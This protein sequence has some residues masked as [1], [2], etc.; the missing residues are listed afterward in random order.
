MYAGG[1]EP[2]AMGGAT[3][4]EDG[5][6][7]Q[8]VIPT[9]GKTEALNCQGDQEPSIWFAD[10]D[11]DGFGDIGDYVCSCAEVSGRVENSDDCDDEDAVVHPG[12]E[13]IC[14]DGVD[15]D[16]DFLID[17]GTENLVTWYLDRDGDGFGDP[18]QSLESCAQVGAS[19]LVAGD[20]NDFDAAIH[21]DA[22]EVC[23]PFDVDEDCSGAADDA[24]EGLADEDKTAWYLDGDEDGY[25]SGDPIMR[26]NQP[27]GRVTDDSDCN[28]ENGDIHPGAEEICDEAQTDENCNGSA[29]DLDSTVAAGSL[30]AWY[31]DSDVDSYGDANQMVASCLAPAGYVEN[32][33]DCDDTDKSLS[34]FVEYYYDSDGDGYGADS[35]QPGGGYLQSCSDHLAIGSTESGTYS[36]QPFEEMP[37]RNLTVECDMV[38]DSG[39]WTLVFSHDFAAAGELFTD[40]DEAA[41]KNPED[42]SA[43]LYSILGYLSS[44]EREE[45]NFE[46]RLE[47]PGSDYA[48]HTW[49]QGT[50]PVGYSFVQDYEETSAPQAD[51]GGWGGLA[52][53]STSLSFLDGSPN[54]T[55]RYFSVGA[56]ESISQE[57]IEGL[58]GPGL[59]PVDSVRL[60][61]RKGRARVVQACAMPDGY[62]TD[63]SDCY[64]EDAF[65]YPGAPDICDGRINDCTA[66]A[67]NESGMTFTYS[68]TGVVE[69]LTSQAAAGTRDSPEYITIP[70]DGTVRICPGNWYT[71]FYVKDLTL[72]VVGVDADGSSGRDSVALLYDSPWISQI[73]S[74]DSFLSVSGL[75]FGDSTGVVN[76][77]TAIASVGSNG[78]LSVDDVDFVNLTA[79]TDTIANTPGVYVNKAKAVSITNTTFDNCAAGTGVVQIRSSPLTM[80]NVHFANS[81]RASA[82]GVFHFD[83]A[84]K[85]ATL[86]GVTFQANTGNQ[87]SALYVKAGTVTMNGGWFKN[88]TAEHGYGGAI[89]LAGTDSTLVGTSVGFSGNSPYDMYSKVSFSSKTDLDCNNLTC[90]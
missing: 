37:G 83:S 66:D 36:I 19:A 69:D 39:G 34:Q 52:L 73:Y 8:S 1:D 5:Q 45:E 76:L 81:G 38:A 82:S 11:E 59:V 40:S 21:P 88:N 56:F 51:F 9:C 33:D 41:L 23:D 75:T 46:F 6:A 90:N 4:S 78:T 31:L 71:G 65:S 26:C 32:F 43:S 49:Y 60:W 15:N 42:P 25:G 24:D 44:F 87:G 89:R 57:G 55:T 79:N 18:D 2:A 50:N 13:D 72:S 16:C 27:E 12:A 86:T 64:P 7:V 54:A 74:S 61:V 62:Q 58:P 10:L 84:N 22:P 20:C 63:V 29:D 80:S 67:L 35:L 3:A 17:N 47:W 85:T 77:V 14:G 30:S 68:E 28:D 48:A 70:G 53:S